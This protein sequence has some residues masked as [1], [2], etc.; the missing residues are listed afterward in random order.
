MR[1]S[2]A[3]AAWTAAFCGLASVA[4]AETSDDAPTLQQLRALV[5]AGASNV[6]LGPADCTA[7]GGRIEGSAHH[8]PCKSGAYCQTTSTAGTR[9]RL[10]LADTD[11]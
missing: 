3:Q 8:G 7:L 9:L 11:E 10:C 4:L 6:L 2:P 5:P 1:L